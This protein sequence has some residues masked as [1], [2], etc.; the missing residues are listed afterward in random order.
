MSSG[1][2]ALNTYAAMKKHKYDPEIMIDRVEKAA[3]LTANMKKDN[4]WGL[5]KAFYNYET[6]RRGIDGMA[7]F[8]NIK[9]KWNTVKHLAKNRID[10]KK[11]EFRD[12]KDLAQEKFGKA[13]TT[14]KKKSIRIEN[15]NNK[16]QQ[17]E[18]SR[19]DFFKSLASKVEG[20]DT[21]KGIK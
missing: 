15:Q 21:N 11:Q 18:M 14:T 12:F 13:P 6:G 17:Q 7:P 4:M 3:D 19:R 1:E 10:A 2:S 5:A 20:L 9:A 16:S 8:N